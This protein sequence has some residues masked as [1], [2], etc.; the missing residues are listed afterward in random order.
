LLSNLSLRVRKKLIGW[1][2]VREGS[3]GGTPKVLKELLF[4]KSTLALTHNRL[5]QACVKKQSKK[6]T[7]YAWIKEVDDSLPSN[8]FRKLRAVLPRKHASLLF[9]L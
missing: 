6:S 9:Q 1:Q 4:S 5:L 7:R 3:F 8:K 2:Q